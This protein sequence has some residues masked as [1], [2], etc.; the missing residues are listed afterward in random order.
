M[1]R[2]TLIIVVVLIIIASA[3]VI[4]AVRLRS[5]AMGY[6][7]GDLGCVDCALNPAEDR[8]YVSYY[9]DNAVVELD[10]M[11]M[12]ETRTFDVEAPTYMAMEQSG[13]HLYVMSDAS[14][15]VLCRI[16]L[17][18][19]QMSQIEL[20]GGVV[21]LLIDDPQDRIWL[22]HRLYPEPDESISE[23]AA[24]QPENQMSGRLA[25][26]RMSDLTVVRTGIVSTVPASVLYSPYS[27]KLY[28]LHEFGMIDPDNPELDDSVLLILDED[29][30]EIVGEGVWGKTDGIAF[31]PVVPDYWSDDGRYLAFPSPLPGN[32]EF[33]LRVFDTAIDSVAFDLVLPGLDGAAGTRYV[34][35]IQ[36]RDLLWVAIDRNARRGVARVNTVTHEYEIFEIPEAETLFGDFAASSDCDTLY[37]T[38][39]W[40]GEILKW[41]AP[42]TSP[43]C[44]LQVVTPMPYQGPS[45]A[46]IEFDATGSYDPDP[47]DELTFEWDFD[48]DHIFNE[49]VDDAYTGPPDNPTHYYTAS[50]TGPVNLLLT[51]N[52]SATSGCSVEVRVSSPAS[53]WPGLTLH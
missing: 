25:E 49:P 7:F 2:G 16:R 30:L 23:E 8:L 26:V 44:D 39:P 48:G 17:Q 3:A 42:N 33:S 52:H 46:A 18:D 45:P 6:S 11:Q 5:T 9:D 36:G 4:Y 40:T 51:D 35:K 19:G 12:V 27:N 14:P 10:V 15:G 41:T 38:L 24:V 21:G 22:L 47:C 53:H 28:T 31:I 34:H 13:L 1:T 43:I 50:Y 20:E 32:P 37:L 29:T